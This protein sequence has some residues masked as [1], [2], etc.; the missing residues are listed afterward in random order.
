M[1]TSTG[2]TAHTC[3]PP[4]LVDGAEEYEVEEILDSRVRRG[5][6]LEY[7]VKWFGYLMEETLRQ[8]E[9]KRYENHTEP[10]TPWKLFSWEDGKFERE[11]LEKLERNWRI[12]KGARQQ[13]NSL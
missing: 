3:P 1:P 13:A 4:D 8:F 12:W 5:R 11:Y 7:L 6:K 2:Q 10:C 9:F